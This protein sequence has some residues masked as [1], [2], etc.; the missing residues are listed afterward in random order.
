MNKFD[1]K[2]ML[3]AA[4]NISKNFVHSDEVFIFGGFLRDFYLSQIYNRRFDFDD[5]DFVL[6]NNYSK[7]IKC[8]VK[9]RFSGHSTIIYNKK[10]DFWDIKDTYSIKKNNLPVDI[11]TL[12]E[13]TVYNI[14]SIVFDL[15][16]IKLHEHIFYKAFECKI[17]DFNDTS[18]LYDYPEIQAIRAYKFS[19][20]LNFKLSENVKGFIYDVV[21]KKTVCDFC[22]ALKRS[23]HRHIDT[24]HNMFIDFKGTKKFSARYNTFLLH[25]AYNDITDFGFCDCLNYQNHKY[26]R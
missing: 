21:S 1:I 11:Y 4:K 9:N 26:L 12:P 14:N 13:T 22:R 3:F 23:K 8:S 17:I 15:K 10:V 18:Y 19:K 2:K 16:T 24:I 6:K 7:N 20:K 25:K 5:I